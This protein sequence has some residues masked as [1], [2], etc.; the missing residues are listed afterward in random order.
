MKH[1]EKVKEMTIYDYFIAN[2]FKCF[3]PELVNDYVG[4]YGG[5]VIKTTKNSFLTDRRDI[6]Q[7]TKRKIVL[8]N[9]LV[10]EGLEFAEK[11]EI[12]PI[13]I[14]DIIFYKPKSKIK[15]AH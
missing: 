9:P 5:T 10:I 6:T 2:N 14:V 1:Y 11:V 7:D 13:Y 4:S 8:Y 3:T 12:N 15:I